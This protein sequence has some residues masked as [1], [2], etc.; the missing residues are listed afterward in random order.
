LNFHLDPPPGSGAFAFRIPRVGRSVRKKVVAK[1]RAIEQ[2]KH[3][4]ADERN[5]QT[6]C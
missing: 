6:V 1:N 3:A 4:E 2:V 5:G